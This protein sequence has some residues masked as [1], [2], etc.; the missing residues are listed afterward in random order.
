MDEAGIKFLDKLYQNLYMSDAVQHTKDNKD[1]R[2]DAIEKYLERLDRVS[3]MAD[4]ES[5]KRHLLNLLYKKYVI[6]EED[7]PRGYPP[8]LVAD[9]IADQKK[10]LSLWVDYLTDPA[11]SYPLWAKYWAFQGMLKMGAFDEV[12]GKYMTRTKKTL[13]PF[14]PANPEIIAKSIEAIMKLV[15]GEKID[16]ITELRLS[17]TDS[18]SKIY[19]V[20]EKKYKET[21]VDETKSN[22]GIWVKYNQGSEEEAIKLSKSLE[23][24]NTGWC[25]SGEGMA[26]A[27]LCGPYEDAPYGGDFYVYYTKDK[28]GKYT[29]PRIAIRL[30][31]K[32]EIGEIRGIEEG[33]NLEDSMINILKEKLQSMD[34]LSEWTLNH[35][36]DKI[37]GLKELSKIIKKHQNHEQLTNQE[38][39]D[40]YF[41]KFGF[42]WTQ[43]PRVG[44]VL[45][46]RDIKEDYEH[47][48]EENKKKIIKAKRLPVSPLITDKK[49]I[50]EYVKE[51]GELLCYASEELQN[52]R[53][54]V[55][56][57][58]KQNPYALRF[59][60]EE[61][62][63]DK[64]IVLEA[65]GRSASTY[66]YVSKKLKND[67]EIALEVVKKK[68]SSIYLLPYEFR[69]DKD[70]ILEAVKNDVTS[71]TYIPS[72]VLND[73]DIV[74][75]IV[76]LK[77]TALHFVSDEL[78]DDK[79]VVLEAVKE[80]GMALQYA[81]EGL[82][83]DK[84][85]VLEAVK[86]NVDA[87]VFASDALRNDRDIMLVVIKESADMLYCATGDELFNDKEIILIAVKQDGSI[88]DGASE[89]L[90]N[91]RE[92]VLAAVRQSGLALQY[93]SE[94]LKNDKE[95]VLE[96]VK[97]KGWALKYASEELKND[98]EV[99]LAAVRQNGLA[100]EYAS[101]T[102]KN[103]KEVVLEAVK[104]T[105][106][107]LRFASE[108]LKNDEEILSILP[109]QDENNKI[110][111]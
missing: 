32:D 35:N 68:G 18:F 59:A 16:E 100:L 96:A 77:G 42:G 80:D 88:L 21:I 44:K 76:K 29:I 61:L 71:L 1:S 58:I 63:G 69:Y 87:I 26:K 110:K 43:D 20:F 86:Q 11:T 15:G 79:D 40:L 94:A 56:T 17:K 34:F 54:V 50:L 10:S 106:S 105:S 78:K 3:S 4:T 109:K 98:R 74:L 84:E 85:I 89:E 83:D 60:S 104:Q 47:C 25:T 30:S 64:E 2:V 91:D 23:N 49:L 90:Q 55:L 51:D 81:S 93:A 57:A 108:E 9:I 8:E 24:K 101:E 48:S 82:R 33:Q 45:K 62:R 14:V 37:K 6:K 102:L 70:I 97:Q 52:D 72:S 65:I 107:A 13:V 67:K 27:Q 7:I 92:V 53:E 103:D 22:E 66:K 95:V 12:K 28:D 5:K 31:G 73:K 39:I 19:S 111:M 46:E 99:V 41:K 75:E 38:I 36:L